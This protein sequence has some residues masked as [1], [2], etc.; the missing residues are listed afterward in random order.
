M[1]HRVVAVRQALL[2]PKDKN[3]FLAGGRFHQSLPAAQVTAGG[4]RFIAPLRLRLSVRERMEDDSPGSARAA[5]AGH[6]PPLADGIQY[7]RCS[8]R[9]QQPKM[10]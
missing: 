2:L 5:E 4:R 3:R 10:E 8:L 1:S 6:L 7:S 9:K